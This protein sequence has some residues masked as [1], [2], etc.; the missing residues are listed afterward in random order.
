MEGRAQSRRG[1]SA[2]RGP[3]LRRLGEAGR[4]ARRRGGDGQAGGRGAGLPG[5]REGA[6][7]A[8]G[9]A[10]PGGVSRA[11]ESRSPPETRASSWPSPT[12]PGRS[13]PCLTFPN[14][15]MN[16]QRTHEAGARTAAVARR[17]S[18]PAPSQSLLSLQA[19][20]RRP[21]SAGLGTPGR[22][23]RTKGNARASRQGR[24]VRRG[25]GGARLARAL[26]LPRVTDAR[27]T[28]ISSSHSG[29][30]TPYLGI[31]HTIPI[32]NISTKCRS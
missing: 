28:C 19:R 26:R 21:G 24:D 15:E 16:A 6:R 3:E 29:F 12:R 13:A 18:D 7:R 27:G 1:L 32:F 10:R 20:R 31:H 11:G 4:G 14:G 8:R 22:G 23:A 25:Q 9:R 30:L 5:A 17:A 2:E